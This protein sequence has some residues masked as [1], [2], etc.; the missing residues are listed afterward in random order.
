MSK[1]LN[2]RLVKNGGSLSEADL[3]LIKDSDVVIR[4]MRN[5]VL[6]VADSRQAEV[7]W[8]SLTNR[9]KGFYHIRPIDRDNMVFQLWFELEDDLNLFEKQLMLKKL[10]TA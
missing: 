5:R 3:N 7:D 2:L 4:M 1:R 6:I 9:V 10:A 8:D